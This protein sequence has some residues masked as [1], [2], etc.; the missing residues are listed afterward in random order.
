MHY[1]LKTVDVDA[2]QFTGDEQ[3]CDLMVRWLDLRGQRKAEVYQRYHNGNP[4]I[5]VLGW[6]D[7]RAGDDGYR[8]ATPGDW[9][10]YAEGRFTHMPDEE[11]QRKFER[12]PTMDD[13]ELAEARATGVHLA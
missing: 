4:T 1:R 6:W 8:E 13:P 9:V 10:I 2:W 7:P 5:M 11:F 12:V 3:N